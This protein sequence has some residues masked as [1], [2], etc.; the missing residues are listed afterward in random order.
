MKNYSSIYIKLKDNRSMFDKFMDII[1]GNRP[2]IKKAMR[3][4]SSPHIA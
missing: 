4:K 2:L 3:N 1:R